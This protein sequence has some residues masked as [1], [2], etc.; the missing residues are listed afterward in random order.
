MDEIIEVKEAEV[1]ALVR[2]ATIVP[3][4]Y[5]DEDNSVEVV[6]TTGARRRAYDWWNGTYYD[7][8]LEVSKRSI[9]MTRF[10]AGVVQVLDGHNTYGGVRSILGIA[11]EGSVRDGEARA[12]LKLSTD[13][14]KAGVVG[15]VKAGIIRSISFGY[16][17]QK[18]EVTE[19]KARKDGGAVPLY[20][21]TQW[22]P[23]EISFV[24]VPADPNAST[25]GMHDGPP[26]IPET[27]PRSMQRCEFVFNRAAVPTPKEPAMDEEQKRAAEEAQ[28]REAEQRAAAEAEKRAR[29]AEQARSA[30][31]TETCARHGLANLAG[32]LIRSGATVADA[33]K[34]VLDELS[35]RDA[36]AGGH[37]G[38][39]RI[40]NGRTDEHTTRMQGMQEAVLVRMSGNAAQLTD[41]GRQFTGMSLL[42]M[43]REMLEGLGHNTR[44]MSK[45][46][47][48]GAMLS[49]RSQGGLVLRSGG[50]MTVSDFPSLMSNVANKRLRMGY[51]ENPGTYRRWAR[52]APNLPDFKSVQVTQFSA[53]PDLLQTN[54][55]GEFKYGSVSDGAVSYNLVTYGRIL[56]F[57]RQAMI[58]DDLRAFDRILTGFGASAARL[59]NRTVY[60]QITSN[61]TMVDGVALFHASHGNLAGAGAIDVTTLGAGRKAMRKQKGLQN[62]ELNLAPSYLLVPTDLEQVAYQYTS[63][64]YVPATPGN[65]NEFRAGGRTALEP[66]IEPILDAASASQW[67]L[68]AANSQVDTVEYAYLDGAEGV[69]TDMEVGFEVDGVA[70]KARLDFVAKVIDY[71]GLFRNG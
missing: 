42:E 29:E 40:E 57:T 8:E 58:N 9:D 30:E 12:R 59:E 33:N 69:V 52:R 16:S 49:V 64:N 61:P 62:E 51:E 35:K 3:S 19:A 47:L 45:M 55:H 2:E 7:E 43:G 25:R 37:V 13:P 5:R 11:L 28:K 36:A 18:Y 20:R 27:V 70:I 14:A 1:P 22:T 41:N 38:A 15:D 24:T 50:M 17:V 68:A 44:G 10:D 23:H 63:A 46:E 21:A 4:S 31:I 48:A 66:I 53:M 32:E 39:T 60:A 34:K 54:E 6:W 26:Q 56:P 65:I 71:R 67:Y